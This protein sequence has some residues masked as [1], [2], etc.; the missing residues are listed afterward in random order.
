MKRF[1]KDADAV[2]RLRRQDARGG[3]HTAACGDAG[4]WRSGGSQTDGGRAA[5]RAGAL[6]CLP[7]RLAA[8]L[9]TL[10]VACLLAVGATL[11]VAATSGEG[12]PL[13]STGESTLGIRVENALEQ[14][15]LDSG[16]AQGNDSNLGIRVATAASEDVEVAFLTQGAVYHTETIGY[17]TPAVPPAGVPAWSWEDYDGEHPAPG[18]APEAGV[19]TFDAWCADE[20][21]A[22][23]FDFS[24]PL[25]ADTTLY[26]GWNAGDEIEITLHGRG[27]LMEGEPGAGDSADMVEELA[28]VRWSLATYRAL[29]EPVRPGYAFVGWFPTDGSAGGG[30]GEAIDVGERVR[31]DVRDLWARWQ[32]IEYQV[33]YVNNTDSAGGGLTWMVGHT[34]DA[35]QALLTWDE[36]RAPVSEAMFVEPSGKY[37]DGWTTMFDGTGEWYGP[38]SVVRNLTDVAGA[39]VNLYAKWAERVE[40]GPFTVTFDFADGATAPHVVEGVEK[41]SRIDAFDDPKRSGYQFAGWVDEDGNAWDFDMQVLRDLSLRAAWTLRLDVTVPVSVAFA[42]DAE[43]GEATGPDAGAYALKS[44]TVAPVEV[45]ALA[46][47]S[48]QGELEGIFELGEG[49]DGWEAPLCETSLSVRS[50]HAAEA[51]ALPFAEP[52]GAGPVWE[53]V[54]PLVDAERAAWRMPAFSYDSLPDDDAWAGADPSKRLALELGLS[55]SDRLK[56]KVGQAGAVPITRLKMTVMAVA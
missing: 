1:A 31:P 25:V 5:G 50:E 49:V 37:F 24:M 13:R 45:T 9:V 21:G 44:R 10:A 34:Y 38:G 47:E 36:V 22:V 40:D 54:R 11:A 42:V 29:P 46:L 3:R 51:V 6:G 33:R 53:A 32:P 43:T 4:V 8:S 18:L 23:A 15:D 48:R 19:P 16:K 28:I 55:V 30:W 14:G 20:A 41:G 27:G 26:A 7:G 17:G 56:V 12:E 52:G 39:Y 35:D 2:S